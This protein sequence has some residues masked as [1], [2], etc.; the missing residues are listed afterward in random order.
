MTSHILHQSWM[1]RY[2]VLRGSEF[3]VCLLGNITLHHFADG[4]CASDVDSDATMK[5]MPR[6]RRAGIR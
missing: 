1:M 5:V 6:S 4:S 3:E 2:G